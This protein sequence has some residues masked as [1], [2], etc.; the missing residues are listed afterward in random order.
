[1]N[2]KLLRSLALERHREGGICRVG[3]TLGDFILFLFYFVL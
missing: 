1:M 2:R 3:M